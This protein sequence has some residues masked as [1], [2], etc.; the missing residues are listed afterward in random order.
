MTSWYTSSTA[1][2]T[3]SGSMPR[4]NRPEFTMSR[5]C[6]TVSPAWPCGSWDSW[7]S[8]S[9]EFSSTFMAVQIFFSRYST[10]GHRELRDV[11]TSPPH[12]LFWRA[13][14]HV[15]AQLGVQE[16]YPRGVSPAM[17]GGHGRAAP[18]RLGR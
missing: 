10:C 15:S 2:L 7:S 11:G 13:R 12:P 6:Q 3:A 9:Q 18:G 5:N 4:R 8:S 1:M 17:G 14:A 16:R